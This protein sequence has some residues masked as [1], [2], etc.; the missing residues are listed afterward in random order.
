[1]VGTVLSTSGKET[2]RSNPALLTKIALLALFLPYV[3]GPV[4]A[5]AFGK[6]VIY[7][8]DG[9]PNAIAV[10]DFNSDG[11]LDLAVS[12]FL[13]NDVSI[14]LGIGDGTF[15][16]PVNYPVGAGPIGI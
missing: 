2:M 8:A 12:N 5:K 16:P 3:S 11:N 10:A 13:T 14:L 6:P 15:L 7:Q 1:M 4:F 9:R